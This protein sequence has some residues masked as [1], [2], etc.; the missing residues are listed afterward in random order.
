MFQLKLVPKFLNHKK[1]WVKILSFLVICFI[2]LSLY[3]GM[4]Q[5]GLQ[6]VSPVWIKSAIC[7]LSVSNLTYTLIKY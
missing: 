5:L 7:K 2:C 4:M 6:Q 1:H 3:K